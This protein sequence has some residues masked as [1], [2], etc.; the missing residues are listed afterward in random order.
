ME[1]EYYNNNEG[2]GKGK[3]YKKYYAHVNESGERQTVKEHDI[4]VAQIAGGFARKFG[5]EKTGEIVGLLHDVGKC[6]AEFDDRLFNGGPKVD[7]ATAGVKELERIFGKALQR[8]LGYSIIGHHSGLPDIGSRES[9]FIQR[10]NKRIPEYNGDEILQEIKWTVEDLNK[11]LPKNY[12]NLKGFVLGFYIRMIYSVLTDADFLDTEAFCNVERLIERGSYKSFELLEEDF[13]IY[14]DNLAKDAKLTFINGIRNEIFNQCV[15]MADN[16]PNLFSLTVPTGGGKTLSSLAFAMN[17]LKYN[18]LDRII[19][20]IPYTS[21][22]EQNAEVYKSILGKENVLEHHSNFD[23]SSEDKED[24]DNTAL[25]LKLASENWDIP[26]VVTTNVQFFES[27]FSNKSSRCRKLHN[28]ANSVVVIDEAQMLP[29]KFLKPTIAAINELVSNYNSTVLLSTATKPSFPTGISKRECIEIIENPDKLYNDLKRVSVEYIEDISDEGLLSRVEDEDRVLIIV[30]TRGHAQKLYEAFG[31]QE[32][33]FHLSANMC[34]EHR[35]KKLAEIKNRLKKGEKCKVI[36]T[37]LIEC[38]VDIS[39]PV[40]YRSISGIDSIVQS[41][42]RCNR[43]GELDIGKVFVFNSTEEY[44]KLRGYQSIVADC[45]RQVLEKYE[46]P[47]SLEAISNYFELLYDMER[48]NLDSKNIMMNFTTRAKELGFDFETTARDYKLIE[49][50]ET[51]II[52][53]DEKADALINELRY[54]EYPNSCLRKLQRYS[55]SIHDSKL[56]EL[57]VNG[58]VDKEILEK[59]NDKINVLSTKSGFY[60]EATGFILGKEDV[61]IC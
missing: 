48:E 34:P 21:I 61:L 45:G 39:F 23:F 46:D 42:G 55:I 6:S 32:Y 1:K 57:Y 51:L 25:K 33:V 53:Y 12:D 19:F 8:L 27:L 37:Q 58:G 3:Y 4:N 31:N 29:T 14:M 24:G 40:V 44:A 49:E 17:H 59:V 38:G 41:A 28:I 2:S 50:S 18:N 47:I 54:S 7:H 10:I 13:Q 16:K 15:K 52:P 26:I 20:V 11:E 5:A 60:D 9:G 30:N 35:S 22:I 56:K 43:E 36:S